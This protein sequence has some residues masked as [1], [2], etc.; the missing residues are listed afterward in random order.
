[1][2][3]QLCTSSSTGMRQQRALH[4][5]GCGRRSS[6]TVSLATY[7]TYQRVLTPFPKGGL[8]EKAFIMPDGM[9]SMVMTVPTAARGDLHGSVECLVAWVA[10]LV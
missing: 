9:A 1:M 10:V 6:T 8:Q 5:S 2:R 7:R 3:M 4:L